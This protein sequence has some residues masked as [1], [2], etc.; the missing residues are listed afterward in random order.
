MT[1]G[2][3]AYLQIQWIDAVFNNTDPSTGARP[4]AASGKCSTVCS[5]DETKTVGV[6]VLV[7]STPSGGMLQHPIRLLYRNLCRELTVTGR[8]G[9]LRQL[10]GLRQLWWASMCCVKIQPVCWKEL[11]RMHGLC[12]RYQLQVPERLLFAMFVRYFLRIEDVY[13]LAGSEFFFH[14][15]FFYTHLLSLNKWSKIIYDNKRGNGV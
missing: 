11:E 1:V 3:E 9:R 13:L 14:T 15:S 2:S 5:I 10:G 4:N 12:C 7:T 8:S 6:P